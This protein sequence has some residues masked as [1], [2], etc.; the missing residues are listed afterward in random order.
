MADICKQTIWVTGASSGLGRALVHALARRDNQVIASARSAEKLEELVDL[1]PNH[2]KCF[3]CD[4][5]DPGSMAALADESPH[6]DLVLACAGTCEYDDGPEFDLAMYRRVF[7]VNFFGAVNSLKVAVPLLKRSSFGGRFAFVGSLSSIA[8][9][10]RAEAYGSSK[11]AVDYLAE[12]AM[13]DLKR[14]GVAVSLVRPGFVDTPLTQKNDFEM[15]FLMPAEEAA[16]SVIKGLSKGKAIIDFPG[17]LSL[18]IKLLSKSR[19]FWRNVVA[20]RMVKA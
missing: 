18:P 13:I 12:T 2:V 17:K 11:A 5:T 3:S 8:P 6:L 7:E 20:P 15:P 19:G 16:E 9:F 14:H 4:V 10:P 1:Y